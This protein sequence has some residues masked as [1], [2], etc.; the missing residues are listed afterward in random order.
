[1]WFGLNALQPATWLGR[2]FRDEPARALFAG[3]AAHSVLRL[4]EPISSAAGLALLA[5]AHDDGWPFPAGG[6]GRIPEALTAALQDLGGS[7]TTEHAIDRLADLPR[8]RVALF[9]T[10]PGALRRLRAPGFPTAT[11]NAFAMS[12]TD[13]LCSMSTSRSTARSPGGTP[14]SRSP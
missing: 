7:V 12:A 5:A 2:R 1:A 14:T 4:D 11:G 9:D 6:A 8:S 3:V 13:H 10:S